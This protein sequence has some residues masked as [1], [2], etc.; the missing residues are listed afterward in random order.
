M[1]NKS[2]LEVKATNY[3]LK[4]ESIQLNKNVI[5]RGK[6]IFTRKTSKHIKKLFYISPISHLHNHFDYP[7]NESKHA[8]YFFSN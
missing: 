3:S 2:L 1:S 8:I 6:I 5:I 7:K 4:L